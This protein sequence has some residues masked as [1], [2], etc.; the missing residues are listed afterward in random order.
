MTPHKRPAET[1]PSVAPPANAAPDPGT[2]SPGSGRRTKNRNKANGTRRENQAKKH[3]EEDGYLVV[4][5]AGSLGARRFDRLQARADTIR[6]SQIGRVPSTEGMERSLVHGDVGRR[7]SHPLR[8]PL[9]THFLATADRAEKRSNKTSALAGLDRRRGRTMSIRY[10]WGNP[11]N[12]TTRMPPDPNRT[13]W[14]R[15]CQRIGGCITNTQLDPTRC[16]YCGAKQP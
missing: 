13:A 11:H 1:H 4:R 12:P 7:P 6:P 8:R 9:P 3:L 14:Q 10:P 5:A 15:R 2:A 16:V